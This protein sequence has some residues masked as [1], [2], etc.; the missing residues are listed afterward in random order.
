MFTYDK[1][2][3]LPYAAL[4]LLCLGLIVF[5]RDMRCLPGSSCDWY[6]QYVS[7]AET[8]RQTFY[9]TGTLFPGRLPLGGGSNIYNFSYYGYLR[10]D[11]LIGCALPNVSMTAVISIYCTALYIVSVLLFYRL[12]GRCGLTGQIRFWSGVLFLGAGCFFQL[13]RQIV[14]INYM[15]FLIGALLAVSSRKK[16]DDVA[17]VVMISLIIFHS[18]FFA[19]SCILAIYVFLLWRHGT[20]RSW[21]RISLRYALHVLCAILLSGILLLP[22]A[23]VILN[24]ASSKDGGTASLGNPFGLRLDFSGFLYSSYGCGLT[25][26]LLFLILCGLFCK[27][28]SRLRGLC[29]FLFFA[30]ICGILPYILNGFL[31]SRSKVL[32]PLLPLAVLAGA[33]IL[34]DLFLKAIR[35]SFLALVLCGYAAYLQY[36]NFSNAWIWGDFTLSAGIFVLLAVRWAVGQRHPERLAVYGKYLTL[37]LSVSLLLCTVFSFSVH[38]S[39]EYLLREHTQISAFSAQERLTYFKN[40][41]YRSDSFSEPYQTV[42]QTLSSRNGR[43]SMYT[44]TP[45]PLYSRFYFDVMRNPIR[46]NNRVALLSQANPF[47]Q[48]LMGVRYLECSRESLPY[49]FKILAERGDSVLAENP[50]VLPLCYGSTAVMSEE[51]FDALPFPASLEAICTR[52]VVKSNAALPQPFTAHFEELYWTDGKDYVIEKQTDTSFDIVPAEAI[53]GQ[54]LVLT[55]DVRRESSEAAIVTINNIRNKLS[56]AAAPYPNHNTTFTFVLSSP[57]MLERFHVSFSGKFSVSNVHLYALDTSHFGMD[58]D[59]VHP[60]QQN[61]LSGNEVADGT[62][63]MPADGW[64]ITSI[65]MEPGFSAWVDNEPC[66]IRTVNKSFIGFPLTAGEHQIRIVYEP[67]LQRAGILCSAAGGIGLLLIFIRKRKEA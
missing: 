45:N 33:C 29:A 51:V 9:E 19:I 17:L 23:A 58:T 54:I 21:I 34:R 13:H 12:A 48:Y 63:S 47:F 44:S 38:R 5:S 26:V 65:P 56:G 42:N 62:V 66:K 36:I 6:S 61:T 8:M 1:K 37:F 55:F 67:P 50:D 32:I 7:I 53:T 60:L 31:Y 52:S 20:K 10:P 40:G 41:N 46:I 25:L 43:T 16:H 11:I 4:L 15:P 14:F 27:V 39:D 35:P 64:L 30:F 59:T 18:Y 57:E 49:G 28:S 2:K 22:S 3:V 24:C